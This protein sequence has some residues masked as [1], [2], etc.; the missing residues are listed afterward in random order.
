M[1]GLL[2]AQNNAWSNCQS[3]SLLVSM[4]VT[5]SC[6]SSS[7]IGFSSPPSTLRSQSTLAQWGTSTEA[8]EPTEIRFIEP[9]CNRERKGEICIW[10]GVEFASLIYPSLTSLHVYENNITHRMD[11]YFQFW[12]PHLTKSIKERKVAHRNYGG[13][14]QLIFWYYKSVR[15][16]KNPF[17]FYV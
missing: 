1:T 16:R 3:F 8:T 14:N 17:E 12:S 2:I 4:F 15:H 11:L 9:Q 13:H 6:C 5:D 7:C 10:A